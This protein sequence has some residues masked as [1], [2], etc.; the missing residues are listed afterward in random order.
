MKQKINAVIICEGKYDKIKLSSIF[1][2]TIITTDGFSIFTDKDKLNMIK[3]LAE[4]FKIIIIT[5]GDSA[6][7][8]IRNYIKNYI[9]SDNVYN[10]LI[11]DVYG[12]EKRKAKFSKEG[13]L[14]VEGIDKDILLKLI[15][16]IV[17][18][19]NTSRNKSNHIDKMLL[20]DY[21]FVGTTN[22]FNKRKELLNKLKLPERTST[23]S[24]VDVANI[25]YSEDEF[26]N[27]LKSI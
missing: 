12:K 17:V 14:G 20:Y 1:D 13:K 6:G 10:V 23:K 22:S 27:I 19:G 3:S 4:N 26:I 9:N 8:K 5:D 2:A 15:N 25:L 18:D 16:N 7:F 11:P 21:G 24:L